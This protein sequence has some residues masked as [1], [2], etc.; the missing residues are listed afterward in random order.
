[1]L[2]DAVIVSPRIAI[3][4]LVAYPLVLYY[5]WVYR[6]ERDASAVSTL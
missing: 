3:Y 2:P 6:H 5:L 4:G 1:M